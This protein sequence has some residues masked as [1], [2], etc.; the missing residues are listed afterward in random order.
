MKS[1][2]FFFALTLSGMLAA[3]SAAAQQVV[4]PSRPQPPQ[5]AIQ[6][7]RPPQPAI[8]PPRPPQPAIQPSRPQPPQPPQPAIQ[9][10]RPP[11][12]PQPP[13]PPVGYNE[14]RVLATIAVRQPHGQTGTVLNGLYTNYR[15]IKLKVSNM[16]LM[17][18]RLIVSFEYGPATIIPVHYR[19]LPGHDSHVFNVQGTGRRR[20]R[21][22]DFSYSSPGLFNRA[23]VTI[24]GQ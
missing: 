19:L 23:N 20:I 17:L 6:P 22:I 21:R 9:P 2:L 8:Q 13:R 24:L 16:P 4:Q 3:R 18:E 12:Q 11:V 1:S 15:H 7:P 14:W 5:P 10:P